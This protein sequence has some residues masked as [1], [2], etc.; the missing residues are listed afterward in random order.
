RVD[1][2]VTSSGEAY[3]LEI[4]TIPG[5][6]ATS[7]LPKAAAK[8]GLSFSELCARLIGTATCG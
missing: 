8:A 5:F 3:V 7:L 2:R 6:T 1:F 4:N